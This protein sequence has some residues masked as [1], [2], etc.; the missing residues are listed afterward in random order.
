MTKDFWFNLPVKDLERSKQFFR[1]IGFKENPSMAKANHLGSFFIGEKNVVMML[2][3]KE[4]FEGFT[5]HQIAD[6]D[7]GTEALFNIDAES[8]EEVDTL[9][10]TVEKAGGTI[11]APPGEKDGWMYAFGFIDPDGHRWSVLY[12]DMSKMPQ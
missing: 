11:Y 5:A 3:P 8:K 7:K 4:A 6:T 10:K 2:F 12:M 1:D 9:A